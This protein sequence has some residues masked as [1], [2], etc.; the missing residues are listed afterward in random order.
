MCVY[1]LSVCCEC[2]CVCFGQDQEG[3]DYVCCLLSRRSLEWVCAIL[4]VR[5]CGYLCLCFAC[6]CVYMRVC[7]LGEGRR[8]FITGLL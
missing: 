7:V 6:E 2:V 3:L 8:D 1:V 4:G 5:M